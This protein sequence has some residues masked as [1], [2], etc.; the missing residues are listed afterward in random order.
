MMGAYYAVVDLSAADFGY[1]VGF[2]HSSRLLRS[3]IRQCSVNLYTTYMLE[4]YT[5]YGGSTAAGECRLMFDTRRHDLPTF[6]IT[7]QSRLAFDS[8][9]D[10]L[11]A[12]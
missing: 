1:L 9:D 6:T 11:T 3:L 2:C 4:S 7:G 10:C 5:Q 8:V 12:L